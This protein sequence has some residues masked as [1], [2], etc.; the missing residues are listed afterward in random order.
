MTNLTE[1]QSLFSRKA[2][3]ICGGAAACLG[4]L[5]LIGWI[6]GL[7]V[8]ASLSP[9]YIPMAPDTAA[10][11]LAL[12][13][14][15]VSNTL[16]APSRRRR[17]FF[18]AAAALIS[19]Y[20]LLKSVEYFVKVDLT[21]EDILFPIT[22]QL[23]SF[24]IGRMSPLTGT[25]FFLSG[26]T[27]LL[28][29]WD[30]SRQLTRNLAAGFGILIALAGF[31]AIMGYLYGTPLLYGG[32]IIPLAAT[33]S[34][35]FLFLGSGLAAAAGAS[36]TFLR[37][38]AGESVLAKLLRAFVPLITTAVLIQGLASQVIPGLFQINHALLA[39]ISSLIF[40]AI[41]SAIV[42]RVAQVISRDLEIS[43]AKTR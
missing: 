20:G 2:T 21:F 35:A 29:L 27:L 9:N 23:G 18:G 43:E 17:L 31:V 26:A 25:L 8:L 36:S 3:Q 4:A 1:P 19:L 10:I 11:F 39:A 14:I 40:I 7:R 12:G 22:E 37:P 24:P 15:L 38:W 33:T 34:L 42:I 6:S 32:D 13:S 5:G 30:A 41:T 28:I 16:R